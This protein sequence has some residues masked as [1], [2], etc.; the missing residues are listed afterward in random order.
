MTKSEFVAKL[1]EKLGS[2]KSQ[3]EHCYTA[4]EAA[5]AE[6]LR[7]EGKISLVGI[8]TFEIKT[9]SART[10][11]NPA[12]GEVVEIPEKKVVSIKPT[13]GLTKAV[14]G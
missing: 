9:R 7:E 4:M 8:A 13:K 12:T 2:S 3:A 10:G 14:L 5:L 1:A 11:R 6:A